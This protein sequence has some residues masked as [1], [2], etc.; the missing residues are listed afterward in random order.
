VAVLI[1]VLMSVG[2]A[3]MGMLMAVSM[4]MFMAVIA[5]KTFVHSG[6][7]SAEK[8]LAGALL[9]T[10]TSYLRYYIYFFPHNQL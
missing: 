2:Y 6:L 8:G 7:L 9:H 5:V 3:V 1:D 10:G 4:G